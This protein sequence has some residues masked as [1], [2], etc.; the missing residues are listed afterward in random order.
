MNDLD[1]TIDTQVIKD[2]AVTEIED[3]IAAA[4]GELTARKYSVEIVEVDYSQSTGT[5]FVGYDG[6]RFVLKVSET[7]DF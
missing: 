3:A 2:V 7:K 1:Q 4:V 5:S 6:C